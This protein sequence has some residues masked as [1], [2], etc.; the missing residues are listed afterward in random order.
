MTYKFTGPEITA[1][2]RYAL[3]ENWLLSKGFHELARGVHETL[4][5][6]LLFIEILKYRPTQTTW[7][8]FQ[9]H[10]AQIRSRA[11]RLPFPALLAEVNAGLTSPM[12][13]DDD[14]KSLQKVRNCL[15]HRAGIVGAIDVDERQHLVLMLPRLKMFYLKDGN[16]V[17][18]EV[19]AIIDRYEHPEMVEILIKRETRTRSYALGEK[20][21]FDAS[22][23]H[24]IAFACHLFASD[25]AAKL[26]A[27]PMKDEPNTQAPAPIE[28]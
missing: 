10:I 13:F 16:E 1:P 6:G 15:E 12:A 26:P 7:A 2:E 28:L 25:L 19:G 17:E 21:R 8:E 5:E 18:L 20:V 3:Y 22:E 23:F 11:G 14:F 27:K 4:E 24:E 9:A